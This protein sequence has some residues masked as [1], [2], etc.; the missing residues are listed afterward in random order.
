DTAFYNSEGERTGKKHIFNQ[1]A[2]MKFEGLSIAKI[3]AIN[4][5]TD[6]CNM[7][8]IHFL[9]SGIALVQGIEKDGTG[10]KRV[11]QSAKATTNILSDTGENTDRAE[12]TVNSVCKQV[13]VVD[14]TAAAIEAL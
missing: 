14:L 2:F 10:F 5:L 3:K 4:A 1:S 9:N 13:H 11:K 8:W 12:I 7:V 6:C